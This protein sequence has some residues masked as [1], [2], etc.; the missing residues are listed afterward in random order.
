MKTIYTIIIALV[1]LLVPR[2]MGAVDVVATF[3]RSLPVGTD[4]DINNY[5]WVTYSV[6]NPRTREITP[7]RTVEMTFT[8]DQDYQLIGFTAA[9]Q[10]DPLGFRIQLFDDLGNELSNSAYYAN[11]SQFRVC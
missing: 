4:I 7:D 2:A 5:L 10:R 9:G 3:D 8:P 6:V 11:F 1:V